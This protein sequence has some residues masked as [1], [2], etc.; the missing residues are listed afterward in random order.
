MSPELSE[1]LADGLKGVGTV[2]PMSS[3]SPRKRLSPED[4]REEILV[5]AR[6]AFRQ[7]GIAG[8]TMAD[9]AERAGITQTH[10]YRHF[11]KEDLYQHA[12]VAPL[13]ELGDR[14]V[15]DT[16]ELAERPDITRA[17]L[18]EHFHALCLAYFVELVP[19]LRAGSLTPEPAGAWPYEQALFDR[20]RAMLVTVMGDISGWSNDEVNVELLVRAW[21]GLYATIALVA[22]VDDRPVEIDRVAANLTSMFA[23]ARRSASDRGALRRAARRVAD[24]AARAGG[25]SESGDEPAASEDDDGHLR[26]RLSRAERQASII[27]AARDLFCEVGFSGARTQDLAERAGITEAFLYRQFSSKEELYE[28]A[29]E[30]PLEVA[31][32]QLAADTRA[33]GTELQSVAFMLEFNT[34]ALRFLGEH[35]PVLAAAFRADLDRSR[36]FF[37]E[38]AE[39]HFDGIGAAII[40]KM[41]YDAERITPRLAWCAILGSVWGVTMDLTAQRQPLGTETVALHLTRYFTLGLVPRRAGTRFAS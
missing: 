33:L 22:E 24:A 6:A 17:E 38:R 32:A 16:R 18:L 25:A 12:I 9:V 40:E 29:I 5:A 10:L 28:A 30:A 26:R 15:R 41:G 36:R 21:I 20:W 2:Q 19:L 1:R 39:T 11:T 3:T 31:L 14:I 34:L 27:R 13:E 23:P 35:G 37:R 7:T 4:R 8:T